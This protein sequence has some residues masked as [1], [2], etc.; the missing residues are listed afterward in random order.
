MDGS[1]NGGRLFGTRLQ[2]GKSEVRQRE[3]EE[4]NISSNLSDDALISAVLDSFPCLW[5]N[6]ESDRG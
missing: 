4:I 3:K 6:R 5:A 1:G 2:R